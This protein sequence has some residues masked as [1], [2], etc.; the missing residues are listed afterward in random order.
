MKNYSVAKSLLLVLS[1]FCLALSS[2]AQG[3]ISKIVMTQEETLY[4]LNQHGKGLLLRTCTDKDLD[5]ITISIT[6]EFTEDKILITR[7]G[8]FDGGSALTE[9]FSVN[10]KDICTRN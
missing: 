7:K 9:K 1:C 2:K 6:Y 5:P 3:H 8:E 10:Y 4:W